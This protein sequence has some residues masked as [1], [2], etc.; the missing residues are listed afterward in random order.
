MTSPGPM[1][2]SVSGA[3][4]RCRHNS[5]SAGTR[6][7]SSVERLILALGDCAGS[8][9]RLGPTG[10]VAVSGPV[11]L[12]AGVQPD[13]QQSTKTKAPIVE[14][15]A[16]T[17]SAPLFTLL[18]ADGAGWPIVMSRPD[19]TLLSNAKL[20]SEWYSRILAVLGSKVWSGAPDTFRSEV[21]QSSRLRGLWY[22]PRSSPLRSLCNLADSAAPVL[23]RAF[24][25]FLLEFL[26]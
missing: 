11:C 23:L 14:K 12:A 24:C 22:G 15:W 16:L 7:D 9:G 25:F 5:T 17:P 4:T 19:P 8:G 18:T 13:R 10:L 3:S 20:G 2:R 21:T 6:Q 1:G 26:K